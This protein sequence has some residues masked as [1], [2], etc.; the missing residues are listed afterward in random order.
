MS[1]NINWL[2]VPDFA[3]AMGVPATHV[4]DMLRT[5]IL[6][7]TRRGENQAWYIPEDF[8]IEDDG[9]I[10]ELA[11]LPGTITQ[12]TDAGLTDDEILEWLFTEAEELG[13]TPM[14]ALREG[15]RKPVRRAAQALG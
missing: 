5:R 12:L 8:L 1:D 2:S 14:S 15:K 7:A 10:R 9:Q 13:A 11:T 6:V 4:R 3:E